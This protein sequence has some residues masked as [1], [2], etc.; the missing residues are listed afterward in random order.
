MDKRKA[1]IEAKK[2]KLQELRRQREERQAQSANTRSGTEFNLPTA[3]ESVNPFNAQPLTLRTLNDRR[4]I[5]ELVKS[6]VG[7]AKPSEPSQTSIWPDGETLKTR[8][9]SKEELK[10]ESSPSAYRCQQF[11]CI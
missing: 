8:D 3:D 2:A 5:D 9:V 10:V 11:S 1:E 7:E 4:D 6:L